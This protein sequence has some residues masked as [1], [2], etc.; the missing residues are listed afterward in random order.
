MSQTLQNQI[1]YAKSMNG[2]V[3][4]SDGSGTTISNGNIISNNID[5]TNI[6][7][8][9]FSTTDLTLPRKSTTALNTLL[10]STI[11]MDLL[12]QNLNFNT[13][14]R[15]FEIWD[16]QATGQIFTVD[17]SNNRV[18]ID[19]ENMSILADTA[20]DIDCPNTTFNNSNVS[21]P[22]STIT[23]DRKNPVLV[24]YLG[25][26]INVTDLLKNLNYNTT[27]KN[28]E[29]WS[30]N[31]TI[32]QGASFIVDCSNNSVQIDTNI[33]NII[34]LVTNIVCPNL[35]FT[36]STVAFPNT[37]VSFNSFLPTTTI[38]TGFA[39]NNFI[40][41]GYGDTAYQ[42]AG[43]GPTLSGANVW[44]GTNTF[45]T[46]LPT[47]TLTPSLGTQL[48]TKTFADGQYGR[49][50]VANAWTGT[51]TFN[52]NLPTSTLTPSL[53]TQLITKTF[54]DTTYGRLAVANTWTLQNTFQNGILPCSGTRT[55]D[56]Q[57]GGNNQFQYRQATSENNIS[58]GNLTLQGDSDAVGRLNNTGKRNIGIGGQV[59]TRLDSG[60]DMIFIGYQA[61]QN[62][63]STRIHSVQP[64]RCIAIGT[65]SQR[66]NLYATDAISIGYN[67]LVNASGPAIGNI[68]I[69]SNVGN[70]LTYQSNNVLIGTGCG[71]A[72]NDN[73]VT[74]IGY[75][76]LGAAVGQFNS[77]VAIGTQAGYNNNNGQG[78]TFVG[79]EAGFSNTS[80]N[81]NT[82]IGLK[83]GRNNASGTLDLTV[84]IGYN[85]AA[86]Q[87]NECVFGGELISEQV[88][89]TL[90]N[91]VRLACNQS[92]TG[93]A[94]NLSFRTN[95]N[96]LI[97]D[98]T[99]TSINLPTPDTTGVNLGAKFHIIRMV[100]TS[101]I[102]INAP[103]GQTI[104][105]YQ[106]DSTYLTNASFVWTNA[107]GS[108]HILCIGSSVGGT[109]WLM[110]PA[111]IAQGAN[112]LRCTTTIS[113]PTLNYSIPFGGETTTGYHPYFMD[114]TNMNYKPSTQTL[115]TTNQT[116][117]GSVVLKKYYLSMVNPTVL[118]GTSPLIMYPPY[119]EY[120]QLNLA[121]GTVQLP[122]SSDVEI[123]TV[124]RF[125]RIT[126]MSGAIN[127]EVQTG[128]GQAILARNGV[129]TVSIAVFL[130][131]NVTYGSVVFLS[132]NLWAI[133]D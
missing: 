121:S 12:I 82:C 54:A 122:L 33:L 74:G 55:T 124:I 68:C 100:A 106:P 30:D 79:T 60:S 127:L 115:T 17:V 92:P 56:I 6:I 18:D 116:I 9:F 53:G 70:G 58:I 133:N 96:V 120:V 123:G 32:F 71:P 77:G 46:N 104:G 4:L 48:I 7:S 39:N 13:T 118:T 76:A 21:F 10:G 37:N 72:V 98:A 38:T 95:E 59:L 108:I 119:Y 84:C 14:T 2:I 3:T 41:K 47:S 102:T 86:Q 50:A 29:I 67:S 109:N 11:D 27:N 87:S 24:S 45:N 63:G 61:G 94:I 34:S 69:G 111:S 35:T 42:L 43:T 65:F 113:S 8:D 57:M 107:S 28:F 1:T 83:S 129:T 112:S 89:L 62:C 51:N 20:L 81:Y 16:D 132:S 26:T 23:I 128:S 105:L 25:S 36:D 117:T 88:F 131:A 64:Q 66:G 93:T 126:T 103:S 22:S 19:T 97:T 44:T 73:A 49:L 40:T 99:T 101:N 80:G 78:G 52:T 90:P 15:D 85:S 5:V 91:K 125:R 75:Q 114:N 110:L 31:T 130:A